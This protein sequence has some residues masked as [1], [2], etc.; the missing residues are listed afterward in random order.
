[1]RKEKT[2]ILAAVL[3]LFGSVAEAGP[4][5]KI[6]TF[7]EKHPKFAAAAAALAVGS[8]IQYKGTTRCSQGYVEV[9]NEGYGSRRAFDGVSIG[10]G[11]V[12]LFA[13]NKCSQDQP[14]WW[15]CNVL[16]F[17]MPAYQT[18]AGIHDFRAYKPCEYGQSA[19][20]TPDKTWGGLK[21]K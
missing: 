17:G 12:L 18:Y 21:R 7:A 2:V 5:S 20:G 10:A 11:V 14:G 9:C 6:K 16:E 19:C 13:G 3:T 1:M 4:L 8:T 15:F